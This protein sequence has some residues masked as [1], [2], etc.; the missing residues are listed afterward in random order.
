MSISAKM[1]MELRAKTSAGMMDCK[2][3]LIATNGD[4][5]AAIKYLR[6]KGISKAAKKADRETKEGRIYSYIHS[7]GKIG[8][9]V[10]V[11]CETDFVGNNEKFIA[12]CK[13]IAMQIAAT[14]PLA[15]SEKDLDPKILESEREVY[16]N[17]ALNEGKPEKI[18]DKIVDGQIKKFIK[19]NCLLEQE[20]IKDPDKTVK[21]IINEAIM[22]L[23]ENIQVAR[24]VRYS[25]GN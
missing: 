3:A 19:Q 20:F 10:E 15:I 14:N 16:R 9:M 18:L 7:N 11:N 12:L 6:E 21:D 23:G 17:K 25:L 22:A 4:M 2:K 13:D 8:V 24:F 5:E 1:V